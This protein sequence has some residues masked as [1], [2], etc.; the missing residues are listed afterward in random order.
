MNAKDLFDKLRRFDAYPKTLEDF[1]IKTFGGAAVT[2][3]SSVL[4]FILFVSE[5]NYY[6][7]L[8]VHPELFVDTSR[9]QKLRINIDIVFPKMACDF[10]SLDAM[11]VSG[12][13]QIDIHTNL[14]KQRLDLNGL[15][16]NEAPEQHKPGEGKPSTDLE[17]VTQLDPSRCESC[18]GAETPDQKCCN[19][20]D[21]VR[22]AYRKKGWAFQDPN[23]IL[24]CQREGWSKKIEAQKNEGC[25]LF[26]YLE[27]NKVAGNFHIAPGKSFQ[28]KHVHIHDM[29]TFS[30]QKFNIT[31]KINH[32]SF[33]HDYPGIINPLDNVYE[34]VDS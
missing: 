34:R 6:L 17:I 7:T 22:E 1:R 2:V 25:K 27:V 5:L 23:S 29:Q 21:E 3:V 31:H 15:P 11:D 20:C 28:Q 32:L 16:I 12:D 26:G 13:S 33:G 24:Q 30:G 18:Y 4:M 9:G 10:L 14:F 8:E 19:T